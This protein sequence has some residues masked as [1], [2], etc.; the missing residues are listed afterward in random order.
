MT[1]DLV[2]ISCSSILDIS[3]NKNRTVV[4]DWAWI[5]SFKYRDSFVN[6]SLGR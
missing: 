6:F 5:T 4:F 2:K 1:N 3:N